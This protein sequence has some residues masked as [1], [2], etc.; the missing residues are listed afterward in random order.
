MNAKEAVREH[1]PEYLM[2]AAGLGLF[3]ISACLFTAALFH[4]ASPVAKAIHSEFDRRMLTGLAMGLTLLGIIHLPMG[5][6][7]GAHLNPSFTW[8]FFRLGKIRFWDA[9][10]YSLAQF[11]GGVLG[12][13]LASVVL[14]NSISHPA[15]QYA[16]TIPGSPGANIAF[17]AELIISFV[18]MTTVLH[19]SNSAR[20]N[21][22]TPFFAATLV[23][24]YITFEAPLSGMSM[25][26]A[27]TVGSAFPAH[28]WTSIWLYFLAP[29]LGMMIAAESYARLK[30]T[31]QVFCAKFHHHNKKRCIFLCNYPALMRDNLV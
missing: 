21:K 23:A 7:S 20:L 2:E 4:P 25:N 1:W 16:V 12:V 30:G 15:V 3:M 14:Q 29:P 27:R 24:T 18:L 5:K 26:P 10:F 9:V 6:R 17:G 13:V 8:A 28:I 31:A 22:L 11:V 19:V